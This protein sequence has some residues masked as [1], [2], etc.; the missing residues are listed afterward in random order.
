MSLCSIDYVSVAQ[1]QQCTERFMEL[2]LLTHRAGQIPGGER[3]T[4]RISNQ[5]RILSDITFTCPTV[6]TS[7]VL[8]IDVRI[9]TDSRNQYPSVL[10]LRPTSNGYTLLTEQTIFYGTNNIS[11]NGVYNYPLDPPISVDDGN[12]LGVRAPRHQDSVVRVYSETIMDLNYETRLISLSNNISQTI[13]T[14]QLNRLVLVYPIV[15]KL[16]MMIEV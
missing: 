3:L 9:K 12:I 15:G 11:T 14:Q 16:I 6:I 5:F 2:S 8:G 4:T 10:L 13:G 7:L 1:E